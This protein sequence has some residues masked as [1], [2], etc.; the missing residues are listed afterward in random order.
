MSTKTTD[1]KNTFQLV[2]L[3]LTSKSKKRE[4]TFIT[5]WPNITESNLTVNG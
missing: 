1:G 4:I 2:Q 3:S 5:I